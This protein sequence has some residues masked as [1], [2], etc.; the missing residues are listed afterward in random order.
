MQKV[1]GVSIRKPIHVAIHYSDNLKLLPAVSYSEL[2]TFSAVYDFLLWKFPNWSLSTAD[3]IDAAINEIVSLR[4][5]VR[6]FPGSQ[7]CK[8]K[9]DF[10]LEYRG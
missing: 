6:V 5:V 2:S 8:M 1:I 9:E 7:N 10:D 3:M 4:L